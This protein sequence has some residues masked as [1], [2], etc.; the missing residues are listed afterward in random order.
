L[1]SASSR[2]K[3][4]GAMRMVGWSALSRSMCPAN[5]RS[6]SK[7]SNRNRREPTVL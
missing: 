6:R 3:D 2:N 1:A 5:G 4:G 7:Y